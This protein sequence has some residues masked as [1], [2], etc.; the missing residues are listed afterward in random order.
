M[1]PGERTALRRWLAILSCIVVVRVLG[2]ILSNYGLYLPTP[3]FHADFLVGR[4][5]TFF[6]GGYRLAFLAH[7]LAGPP[8]LVL[9]PILASPPLRHRAPEWHARLGRI[10]AAL[11]G[12]ILAPSGLV[13]ALQPLP[14]LPAEERF[15]AGLGFATLAVATGVA[16]AC[17]FAAA[18][19]RRF[20]DHG[21]WMA[22]VVALLLSAVVLRVMGG[23]A[24]VLAPDLPW[25]YPASAWG[26]WIL[27]LL[28]VERF[29]R[30]THT[31]TVS[32]RTVDHR[33]RV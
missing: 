3:D 14:W 11:V 4:E 29:L 27:P 31:G 16:V 33:P 12:L 20:A 8:A 22:R 24:S 1:T 26:S 30:R 9:A 32:G 5:E 25:T 15:V 2:G 21:R 19:Q 10:E 18:R 23:L 13:M 17:G 6:H 7:I 28:A